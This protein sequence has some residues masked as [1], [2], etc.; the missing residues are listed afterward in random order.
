M[1]DNFK[2]INYSPYV[3]KKNVSFIRYLDSVL[4]GF[5]SSKN[6]VIFFERKILAFLHSQLHFDTTGVSIFNSK[7]NNLLF[8]GFNVKFFFN[9]KKSST[10]NFL[11][12]KK[13]KSRVLSRLMRNQKKINKISLER[14]NT[15][16]S[17]NIKNV[18]NKKKFHNS[19]FS[20]K[21][22]WNFAF[23]LEAVRT[24]RINRLV[25]T[26]DKKFP[27]PNEIFA[28]IRESGV[29]EYYRYSFDLYNFQIKIL[30][31][32][33]IKTFYPIMNNSVIPV[34]LALSQYFFE[35]KKRIFFLFNDYD[36]KIPLFDRD[37][38]KDNFYKLLPLSEKGY[39]GLKD[40]FLLKKEYINCMDATITSGF[41]D[42]FVPFDFLISKLR[43]LGFI[44]P[45]KNRPIGSTKLL[46][47]EDSFIIKSFGYFA[48]SILHWYRF[49][50]NLK[51]LNF[52][53]E[54]LR[55]SCFL[56]LCRK[57]NKN[58][59]WAYVT[60]SSDLIVYKGL[61]DTKSFFPTRKL[62]LNLNKNG[63][64][65]MNSFL[66]EKFFLKE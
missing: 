6:F 26:N 62:L 2:V 33:I 66:D 14:F 49:C 23:Q 47:F 41:I 40:F 60:Y 25:F 38:H 65:Y 22:F 64:S 48:Y 63:K 52:F 18:L 44:H 37:L 53:I 11:I 36:F 31:K 35:F 21:K 15:E 30:L 1:F 13:Y 51:N 27:V 34:D 17:I 19:P 42:F 29:N 55:E 56:T 12:N 16:F 32:D 9:E 4:L 10:N 50:G 46:F 45:Y 24:T 59:N 58:K 7:T 28:L 3:Y 57:H 61:F 5:V 39:F 54:L 8:L 20:D 43:S